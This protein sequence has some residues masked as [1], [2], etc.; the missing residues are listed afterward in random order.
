[1]Y[2]VFEHTADLGLQVRAADFETLLAEAGKGLF[3]LIVD[4][5]TVRP[6]RE[7]AFQIE[8]SELDYLFFDWLNELLFAF[9]KDRMLY[10]EF[11]VKRNDRG[12][13]AIARG[14]PYDSSRHELDH[15]VKAIT[16]HGL[17]VVE[18]PG[19]W[20]AEVIVDI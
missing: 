2:Q 8:G 14:E 16:Y 18:E 9:E 12:I 5:G 20:L 17:T 19:G 15:E 11:S 10:S 7:T 13:T 3:S 6:Q 4:P 1:M